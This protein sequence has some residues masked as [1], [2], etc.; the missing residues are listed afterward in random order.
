MSTLG[1]IICATA[2]GGVLSM[3]VAAL[4]AL[5]AK[6]DWIPVLISY[7]VGALLG[8]V[9]LEVLPHAFENASSVQSIAATVLG[10][11]LRFSC[12][13]SSSCGATATWSNARRT[14]RRSSLSTITAAAA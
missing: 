3:A 11:I 2:L 6:A 10:G 14:T 4:F 7:A 5:N 9:F 12:W 1:W 13:R 8:A